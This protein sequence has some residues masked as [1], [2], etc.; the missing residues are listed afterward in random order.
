MLSFTAPG[1]ECERVHKMS[2][3]PRAAQKVDM[4]TGTGDVA[5]VQSNPVNSSV[6]RSWVRIGLVN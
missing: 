4:W 2:V 1:T 5:P 6:H 3:S